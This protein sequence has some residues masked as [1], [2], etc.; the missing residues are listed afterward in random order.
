MLGCSGF[1]FVSLLELALVGYL[2]V[3]T[4]GSHSDGLGDSGRSNHTSFRHHDHE[5]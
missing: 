2:A 4:D 3:R 1:V 5:V